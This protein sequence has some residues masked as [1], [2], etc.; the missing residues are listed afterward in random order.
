MVGFDR[1]R[2]EAHLPELTEDGKAIE[3]IAHYSRLETLLHVIRPGGIGS[4]WATG[5]R[6]LNDRQELLHGLSVF[7]ASSPSNTISQALDQLEEAPDVYQVSFSGAPDELGQWRGYANNGIGCSIAV[8]RKGVYAAASVAGWVIYDEK[9]QRAFAK[10]VLK[11][12]SGPNAVKDP[13]LLGNYLLAAA[14]FMK[15]EGF[16]P[17]KEYRLLVIPGSGESYHSRPMGDRIAP[18][19]DVFE[20]LIPHPGKAV[21]DSARTFPSTITVNRI[22]LGPGWQ[23]SGLDK[24][25][26]AQHHVARGVARHLEK[27]GLDTVDVVSSRIPYDPR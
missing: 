11:A 2:I 17:E 13:D 14:A 7:R 26:L 20:P 23:L 9:K 25:A 12:L 24:G 22:L 1:K 27:F 6:Y 3:E 19:V 8:E 10:K 4:F 15:D 16:S 5:L 18:Y 21:P